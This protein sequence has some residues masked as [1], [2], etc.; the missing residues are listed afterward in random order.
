MS[1]SEIINVFIHEIYSV[2]V[3]S[4][5]EIDIDN[6]IISYIIKYGSE[7]HNILTEFLHRTILYTCKI[8]KIILVTKS[9][10]HIVQ[11]YLEIDK[12]IFDFPNIL[13]NYDELK[14][15][16]VLKNL[17]KYF[18]AL[19]N[20][21]LLYFKISNANF[22]R[23]LLAIYL[24]RKFD[25]LQKEVF[26]LLAV[27]GYFISENN[28]NNT[29]FNML[30]YKAKD[31]HY[32][33]DYMMSILLPQDI[34]FDKILQKNYDYKDFLKECSKLVDILW[35]DR[36][37]SNNITEHMFTVILRNMN[38]YEMERVK[39]ILNLSIFN[40][41][42]F[43][44]DLI[45]LFPTKKFPSHRIVNYNIFHWIISYLCDK[46]RCTI[47]DEL[48]DSLLNYLP[49]LEGDKKIF[50]D[51]FRISELIIDNSCNKI[52][53][54]DKLLQ[55]CNSEKI[56]TKMEQK[57]NIKNKTKNLN[58]NWQNNNDQVL[59]KLLSQAIRQID[60]YENSDIKIFWNELDNIR[61]DA[62]LEKIKIVDI[63]SKS[64]MTSM[65]N[66]YFLQEAINRNFNFSGILEFVNK[67]DLLRSYHEIYG[68][69]K[70]DA[71]GRIIRQKK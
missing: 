45:T 7:F 24:D 14:L 41:A 15:E 21:N 57:K 25:M 48:I 9:Y 16:S 28:D 19:R 54:Y 58:P 47:N 42:S 50:A 13:E 6:I 18:E 1:N 3:D 23:K 12:I 60:K 70:L 22:Y 69:I 37:K 11:N 39:Y 17:G 49:S 34:D 46:K 2:A 40:Y 53:Y 29:K 67:H 26:T 63:I 36:T 27:C 4:S 44:I 65:N 56:E 66:I 71:E 52:K 30:L 5:I 64:T 32:N 51:A 68:I 59:I 43:N 38:M 35:E 62:S 55:I 10:F 33:V 61:T 8:N 31:L 20:E